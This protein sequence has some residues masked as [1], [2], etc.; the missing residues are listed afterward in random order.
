MS[1]KEQK[2]TPVLTTS[3]VIGEIRSYSEEHV[4]VSEV[5]EEIVEKGAWILYLH[6]LRRQLSGHMSKEMTSVLK[7]TSNHEIRPY[8]PGESVENFLFY[9]NEEDEPVML[10]NLTIISRELPLWILGADSP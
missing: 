4:F 6:H 3:S 10:N 1:K 5:I 2:P 9:W 8:D 7:E